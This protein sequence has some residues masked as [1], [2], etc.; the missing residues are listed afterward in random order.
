MFG[1]NDKYGIPNFV[2]RENWYF[3]LGDW[4]NQT[5][6]TRVLERNFEIS[7]SVRGVSFERCAVQATKLGLDFV[8]SFFFF[9][10]WTGW[11]GHGDVW[12]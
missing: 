11:T 5:S 4:L 9:I 8:C 2:L 1:R 12:V 10:E 3:A 7:T 6:D